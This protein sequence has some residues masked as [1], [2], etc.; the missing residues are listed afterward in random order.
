MERSFM[1]TVPTPTWVHGER[2]SKEISAMASMLVKHERD[3]EGF[4][5]AP[6]VIWSVVLAAWAIGLVAALTRLHDLVGH[7]ALGHDGALPEFGTMV[8]FLLG[9][10]V[11]TAGMMLPSSLPMIGSFARASRGQ[12]HP[13]LALAAFLAAYFVVWTG[14]AVFALAVDAGL[15][16][17]VPRWGWLSERPWLIPGVVLILA[18]A[19]Q[20]SS[21]KERC[22]DACRS[23]FGFIWRWYGRG[24][25][26]AWRLGMRHGLFCLGCCWALMLTMFAVGINSLIW[27]AALTGVMLIEKT[28]PW[29]RR[30]AP[31][32]GGVLLVWGG[33][34]LLQ[35]GWLPALLSGRS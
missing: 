1:S 21:L 20:F 32:V 10:Q 19:F 12:A 27:M 13:R 33:L 5:L 4:D 7:R 15:R 31:V 30:L 9:W 34:A 24:L 18:G 35:P 16:D 6:V 8:I 29:G 11:M 25:A 22:L 14:F 26:A 28:A 2:S 3:R 23:P 17:L